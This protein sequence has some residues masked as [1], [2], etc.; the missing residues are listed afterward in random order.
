MILYPFP[1]G[2]QRPCASRSSYGNL[3]LSKWKDLCFVF[4]SVLKDSRHDR[5]DCKIEC[6]GKG[7]P[8]RLGFFGTS[9]MSDYP[10]QCYFFGGN[11]SWKVCSLFD[12]FLLNGQGKFWL[13]QH[14]LLINPRSESCVITVASVVPFLVGWAPTSNITI[15]CR[16]RTG[17]KKVLIIWFLRL[18]S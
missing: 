1:S 6:N 18:F 10:N 14:C 15:R 5:E 16:N 9:G 8:S 13:W 7:R 11:S 3:F 2:L 12:Q 4:F 17:G